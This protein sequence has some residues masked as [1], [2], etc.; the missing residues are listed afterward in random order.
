M[1]KTLVFILINQLKLGRMKQ[2]FKSIYGFAL[3]VEN[4]NRFPLITLKNAHDS[5]L[6]NKS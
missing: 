5:G 1:N 2:L 3:L 6:K 4:T